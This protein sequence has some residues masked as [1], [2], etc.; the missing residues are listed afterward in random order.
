[1]H[2]RT[3]GGTVLAAICLLIG[4][5]AYAQPACPSP[6]ITSAADVPCN[7][8]VCYLSNNADATEIECITVEPGTTQRHEAPDGATGIGVE[9]PKGP[10]VIPP[11]DCVKNIQV[12]RGCCVDVCFD[13]WKCELRITKSAGPCP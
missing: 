6:T 8:T 12:A 1:M 5:A 7:V 10:V 3:F 2:A 13:L 11:G 4:T 9:T